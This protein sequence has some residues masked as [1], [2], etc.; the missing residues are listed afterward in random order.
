VDRSSIQTMSKRWTGVS[1]TTV[2]KK[3]KMRKKNTLSWRGEH[4]DGKRKSGNFVGDGGRG[5][6]IVTV[7]K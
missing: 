2:K 6:C 1:M 7:S 4:E 3:D 5:V